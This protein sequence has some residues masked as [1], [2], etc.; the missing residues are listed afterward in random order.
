MEESASCKAF[1]KASIHHDYT[2]DTLDRMLDVPTEH[3]AFLAVQCM[4]KTQC[5]TT[6]SNMRRITCLC[7]SLSKPT[8]CYP[9][10][11]E[12]LHLSMAF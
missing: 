9:S 10:D 3:E 11:H 8:F 6:P 1:S 2:V 7:V 4:H 12:L 5:F